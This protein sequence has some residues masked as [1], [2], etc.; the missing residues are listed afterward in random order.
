MGLRYLLDT[1]ILSDLVKQPAGAAARKIASLDDEKTCCTS[2][3]VACELRYGAHKKGSAT[4]SQKVNQLLATIAVLPLN[5][6]MAV[7]YAE[8]RVELERMGQPIGSNDLLIAAH[9]RSQG[10]TVVTANVKEFLRVPELTVENW[11]E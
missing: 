2:L 4:L 8:I 6:D 3:V 1:N 10:L 5:D 7:H 11:L 9:A